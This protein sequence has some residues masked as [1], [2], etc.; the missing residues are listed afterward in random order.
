MRIERLGFTSLKGSRHLSRDAVDLSL[1]G[2]VGDRVFCLVDPA[3]GRVL[4]T[5]ENPSLV[6]TV[7]RW[8]AGVLSVDLPG[9][10]VEG[11]PTPTGDVVK[12]D[13]WG[14][15]AAVERVEGPWATAFSEYLG[16]DV[17]LARSVNPGEVVYGGSVTLVSTASMR[18]LSERVGHEV[19]GARFRSTFL[20]DAGDE[21]HVE[22][23]WVGRRL[24]L[25]DATV[26]VRGTVP[27]CAVIDVH[28]EKGVPETS[29]LKTLAGYRLVGN[30]VHFGVDAV[31]IGPGAV[32]V[33]DSAELGRG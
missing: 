12:V 11:T 28:P 13:Y 3:R 33:G 18:L 1:E 17:V 32:R 23:S 31:V 27:R 19:D 5:V 22:D 16:Y 15:D 9:S 14:R 4:R 24:R 10:T 30:E 21:P 8:D 20:I 2:P 29:L 6:R 25:G 26:L 7:A